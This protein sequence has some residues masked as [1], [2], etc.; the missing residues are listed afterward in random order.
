M[1]NI[2]RKLISEKTLELASKRPVNKITVKEVVDACGIT[3]NTFYYHFHD[4]YDVL[5]SILKDKMTE[6]NFDDNTDFD[7][8]IFDLIDYCASY[9]KVWKN[10]Y[11][12]MGREK[13]SEF[14]LREMSFVIEAYIDSHEG[15]ELIN[16]RDRRIISE[17]YGE[18]L[19]GVMIRWIQNRKGSDD[20]A[21]LIDTLNRI[22]KLFAKQID[23]V[24]ENSKNSVDD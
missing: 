13:F 12:A 8:K 21:D 1:S 6:L 4:V 24:I 19:V 5:N 15:A 16:K 22:R 18:G 9:K 7:N 17:F 3:R 14:V 20:G 2:T 11:A 23:L 10:L